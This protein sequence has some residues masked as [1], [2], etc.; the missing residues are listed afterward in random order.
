[1]RLLR[2]LAE[3]DVLTCLANRRKFTE[4]FDRLQRAADRFGQPCQSPCST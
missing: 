3:T 4:E 1:V 2:Q